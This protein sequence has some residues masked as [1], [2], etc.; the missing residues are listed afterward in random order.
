[1]PFVEIPTG[2]AIGRAKMRGLPPNPLFTRVSTHYQPVT[3]NGAVQISRCLSKYALRSSKAD[4]LTD[5]YSPPMP[6]KQYT[7]QLWP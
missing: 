7:P 2:A 1:M 5:R 4:A 3:P 6:W